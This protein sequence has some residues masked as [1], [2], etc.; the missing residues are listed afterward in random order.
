MPAPRQ[1]RG[2]TRLRLGLALAGL[3]LTAAVTPAFVSATASASSTGFPGF[4][5]HPVIFVHGWKENSLLWNSARMSFM[6]SGY[7]ADYLVAWD[8]NTIQSNKTTAAQFGDLAD[9]VLADTGATK[10]DVVTHSMGGLSTRWYAKFLG[11][12]DKIDDWVSLGG[13]NHG[14]MLADQALCGLEPSC[15]EMA[16]DSQ[17]LADLNAG[18]ETPG[19]VSY[20]T[21]WSPCDE[22]VIPQ[23]S[24]ILSGAK[25]TKTVC[26][27][28]IYLAS[29]PIVLEQVKKFVA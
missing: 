29:D 19:T 15:S 22:F 5:R 10:V 14:T 24:T 3:V 2:R 23:E 21:W 17:F 18:D 27:E 16:T 1:F 20:G 26:M 9:K 8:Y 25:N 13:P 12:T 28:H 4:S 7:P 11:G 6:A